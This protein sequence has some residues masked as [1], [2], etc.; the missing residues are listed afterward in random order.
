V[1]NLTAVA[2]GVDIGAVA[3]IAWIFNLIR[4]DQMYV[5]YAA[6]FVLMIAAG[7][8][9]ITFPPVLGFFNHFGRILREAAGLVV[10]ALAFVVLMLIYILSQL[11]QLSNRVTSL[12]Q[13][14]AIRGADEG[15]G[16]APDRDVR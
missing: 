10:L 13:E 15:A 4:R 2:I 11:T 8:I 14:L 12:T 9:A 3:L 1:P 6:I 5:G 16:P 7:M